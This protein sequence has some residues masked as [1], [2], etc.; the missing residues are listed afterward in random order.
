[1]RII[2]L[3]TLFAA[4]AVAQAPPAASTAACGPENVRGGW[5]RLEL[6]LSCLGSA[7][8][9]PILDVLCQG[10]DSTVASRSEFHLMSSAS[11]RLGA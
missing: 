4:S 2:A 6:E 5:P 10:W 1:M 7:R 8:G 11:L 3:V 9:C